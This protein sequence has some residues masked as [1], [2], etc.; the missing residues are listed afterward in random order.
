MTGGA[1]P[2]PP[3]DIIAEQAVL[4]WRETDSALQAGQIARARRFLRWIL[5]CC[6]EDVEAWLWFAR[7][8]PNLDERLGLLRRAYVVHPDSRRLRYE[9]RQAREEQLGESVGEL[10]PWQARVRCLPDDRRVHSGN[11]K[12]NGRFRRADSANQKASSFWFRFGRGTA[13]DSDGE[14]ST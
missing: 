12:K 1:T 14:P 5:A 13:D 2:S 8:T 11:G 10:R 9:M 4:W 7:L 3:S 6:P